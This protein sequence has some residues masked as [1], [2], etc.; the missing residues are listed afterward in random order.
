M[1]N[2]FKTY[3]DCRLSSMIYLGQQ[4]KLSSQVLTPK[5]SIPRKPPPGNYLTEECSET[6][7]TL[8]AVDRIP[9]STGIQIRVILTIG[10]QICL[11]M[12]NCN[13]IQALI[14]SVMTLFV[15]DFVCHHQ[16]PDKYANMCEQVVNL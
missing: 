7:V 14:F 10:S 6:R 9:A 11:P 15:P 3:G 4:M 5:P 12:I 13:T 8:G 2:A 1:C 16:R